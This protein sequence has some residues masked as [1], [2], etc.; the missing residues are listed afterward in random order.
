[1]YA[2]PFSH[3]SMKFIQAI[4]IEYDNNHNIS[5]INK[6]LTINHRND[7]YLHAILY[8]LVRS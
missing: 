8:N 5:I 6:R 2:V 3:D 1:M 4:N 7:Y